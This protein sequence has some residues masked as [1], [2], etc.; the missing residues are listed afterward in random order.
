MKVPT[1]SM[2]RVVASNIAPHMSQ[3]FNGIWVT[4]EP[5][6]PM[7]FHPVGGEH[8]LAPGT[9]IVVGDT[10]RRGLEGNLKHQEFVRVFLPCVGWVNRVYFNDSLRRLERVDDETT[11][12]N[13]TQANEK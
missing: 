6:P 2:W 8:Y 10:V 1:G 5:R 13:G 9:I 3:S 12:E 4:P 7:T 11:I